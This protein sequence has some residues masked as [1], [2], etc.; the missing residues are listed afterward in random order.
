MKIDI[1]KAVHREAES[2]YYS[3]LIVG[4]IC[5]VHASEGGAFSKR[6]VD[7]VAPVQTQSLWMTETLNS[8]HLRRDTLTQ[9]PKPQLQT[10]TLQLLYLRLCR[11]RVGSERAPTCAAS[12]PLFRV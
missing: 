5:M 10:P 8:A 4:E 7:M 9:W 12:H 3:L 2:V 6:Q 1:G 11:M